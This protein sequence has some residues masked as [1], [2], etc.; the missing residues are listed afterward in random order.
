MPA[1]HAD[2][3]EAATRTG[4]ASAP[5][6]RHLSSAHSAPVEGSVNETNGSSQLESPLVVTTFKWPAALGG[7]SVSVIG[8]FN[9]WSVPLPL[10]R[11]ANGDFVRSVGLPPGGMQFKYI[12]DDTWMSS[13]CEQTVSDGAGN[14]NN[15]RLVQTTAVF[16][17]M[18]PL[19]SSS[20]VLITGDWNSWGELVPLRK[21]PKSGQYQL[22]ACLQP[23]TYAYQC[24]VDNAWQL[25][26]DT[27]T[28]HTETGLLANKV[29]V[30]SP[31]A[32][33]VF[34]ATGWDDAVLRVRL[35][36]SDG[37]PQQSGW[38]EVPMHHTASRSR[39]KGG[40]WKT[41]VISALPMEAGDGSAASW[42]QRQEDA[43][44][45]GMEFYVT[46][47]NGSAE[48][49]PRGG[50]SYRL[51]HP[52]G[53]KLRS[54]RVLPFPKATASPMMLVSDLDGTMVG[55]GDDA[56][57]M[58]SDFCQYWEEHSA[59][60]GCVL[61]YNTG[62][63]LGSFV[64]LYQER[65]G[66]LALPDVLIT[67]VGTK[68]FRLDAEGGTRGTAT[69]TSWREDLQ[70]ARSL[71][72]GWDLGAVRR[73]AQQVLGRAQHSASWLDDGS[74]HPHR[75]ALSVRHD[76]VDGVTRQ[77]LEGVQAEGVQAQVI[78]SGVGD[79][80]YVDCVAARAGKLAAL[81]YVRTL[82]GVPRERCVAAGDSGNDIL[83]LGGANPA[84]VVGNA[85]PELVEWFLRQ[86]QSSR[87]VMSDAP[88][89][90][91]LLE[92][93]ARHGLF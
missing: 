56:H 45:V 14:Y 93:L 50:G 66:A 28:I 6:S 68:I 13:P 18:G 91:G 26:P 72:A 27:E 74:E 29:E 20:S 77:L 48:D 84:I 79:W 73:V 35:L 64:H 92:G 55:D 41:A 5:G 59:L 17:W 52:G 4:V 30:K 21:D 38:R 49:R 83:M 62:R 1:G 63:S 71:D 8:S 60:A 22:H 86:P 87:L 32:F 19:A 47:G 61:V 76:A 44:G 37:S 90:R 51:H 43:E 10:G 58:T 81:E 65:G 33:S 53:Y 69:G 24:L 42:Q 25:C 23:G 80:R 11:A 57:S 15:Y 7:S 46:N 85:Q 54:G 36:N 16:K 31:P 88:L 40:S 67:A 75:V 70:W 2:R 9:G 82:Y 89:G 34:Y 12:V 39:P 78:I 3:A